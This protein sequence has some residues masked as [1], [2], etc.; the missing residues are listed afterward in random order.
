MSCLRRPA[1]TDTAIVCAA[2]STQQLFDLAATTVATEIGRVEGDNVPRRFVA[3]VQD[4]LDSVRDGRVDEQLVDDDPSHGSLA[5]LQRLREQLRESGRSILAGIKS[6]S[7]QFE[8]ELVLVIAF[9][10]GVVSRAVVCD[11]A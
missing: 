6:S 5:H 4:L 8:D 3:Q 7:G 10:R 11:V 1:L 9:P 2:V